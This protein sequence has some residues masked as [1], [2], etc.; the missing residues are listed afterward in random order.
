MPCEGTIK[1]LHL[2]GGNGIR[3]DTAIYS[4]Y[5]IPPNYDSMI[6]K[7][8]VHGKDRQESIQKMKSAVAELVVDGIQTNADFILEILDNHNFL[9]NQYDTSFIAKEFDINNG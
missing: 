2:P 4:G 1:G 6:A 7:I 3:V 9:N 8:I 5:T